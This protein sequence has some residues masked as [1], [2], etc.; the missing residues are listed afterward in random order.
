MSNKITDE[1][2]E[3]Q[4]KVFAEVYRESMRSVAASGALSEE[5]DPYL[6]AKV[7]L[8]LTGREFTP[9]SPEGKAL[10]VNLQHFI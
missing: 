7:V 4:L 10:L 3:G 1:V 5:D 2:V 9:R 8:V 6:V